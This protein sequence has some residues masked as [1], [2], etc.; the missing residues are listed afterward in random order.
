MRLLPNTSWPILKKISGDCSLFKDH[1]KSSP[2]WGKSIDDHSHISCVLISEI[3]LSRCDH[4]RTFHHICVTLSSFAI[5][6]F[7]YVV[8]N[9]YNYFF[10]Y[11]NW[12]SINS[13]LFLLIYSFF[14]FLSR[15]LR[16]DFPHVWP[17][18]IMI[19]TKTNR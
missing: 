2:S 10:L 12:L 19:E 14:F 1:L 6:F 15:L 18:Q 13:L 11:Y 5:K 9:R 16:I 17:R 7:W 3:S 4:W 8:N